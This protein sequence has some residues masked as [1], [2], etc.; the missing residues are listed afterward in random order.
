MA[1]LLPTK[2]IGHARAAGETR[3]TVYCESTGC[4]H[5]GEMSFETLGLPDATIFVD[6]AK[7]KG[8]VCTKCG[9]R[10]VKLMPI[11]PA[12]RGTPGY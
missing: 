4:H 1:P 7:I 6:I 8:F 9:R 5:R 3:F 2:T 11:F 10:R 12:A